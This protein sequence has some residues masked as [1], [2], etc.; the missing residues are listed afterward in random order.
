M[1]FGPGPK[2]GP[3]VLPNV[4]GAPSLQSY[5]ERPRPQTRI[6]GGSRSR[7]YV[8]PDPVFSIVSTCRNAE[9]FLERCIE[10]VI[11][12]DYPNI[13]FIIY[14]ACSTDRTP[15]ILRRYDHAITYW[16][17]EPDKGRADGFNKAVAHATGDYLTGLMADDW[18]SPNFCSTAIA[19]I[20][21]SNVDYVVGDCM[22]HGIDGSEQY[23]RFGSPNFEEGL[24]HWMTV[25]SPSFAIRR[26]ILDEI[27]LF[28]DISV[29][30]D[31]DWFL[32]AHLAGNRGAYDPSLL[33]HFRLGGVSTTSGFRAYRENLAIAVKYGAPL[34]AALSAYLSVMA[35]H[36]SR[37]LLQRLLPERSMLA[38]RRHRQKRRGPQHAAV[39]P[40]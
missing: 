12:Q 37:L 30:S 1:D 27:G 14:D 34:P 28:A 25:N 24:R 21:R 35:R 15:D 32:R 40:P 11:A 9:R 8:T 22:L 7:V 39:P 2:N 36:L 17:S 38:L 10:S 33:Y 29:A 6:E 26:A 13:E 19:G 5:R 3:F 31:Y 4:F 18:L 20:R 23:R 16:A